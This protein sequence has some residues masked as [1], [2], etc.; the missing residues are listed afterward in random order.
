MLR[1][2]R[3]RSWKSARRWR[4]QCIGPPLCCPH[5]SFHEFNQPTF[6]NRIIFDTQE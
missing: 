2:T 4:W 1:L 6:C 5:P 3:L